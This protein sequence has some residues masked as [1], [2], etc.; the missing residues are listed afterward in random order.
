[1]NYQQHRRKVGGN[2]AAALPVGAAAFEQEKRMLTE[3]QAKKRITKTV[4]D[5]VKAHN[6]SMGEL[7][8]AQGYSTDYLSTALRRYPHL[9]VENFKHVFDFGSDVEAWAENQSRLAKNK[10]LSSHQPQHVVVYPCS[11]Q[12]WGAA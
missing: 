9:A 5:Y 10:T 1:M 2:R 3:N 12:A 7:S 8:R 11:Y 6:T 4:R